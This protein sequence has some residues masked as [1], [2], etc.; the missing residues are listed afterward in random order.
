MIKI[1]EEKELLK[2]KFL[3]IAFGQTSQSPTSPWG[4]IIQRVT[5]LHTWARQAVQ[6]EVLRGAVYLSIL[7]YSLKRCKESK[8]VYFWELFPALFFPP[9]N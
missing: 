2:T 5:L 1:I 8:A 4:S 6:T 3:T 7:P 9:L